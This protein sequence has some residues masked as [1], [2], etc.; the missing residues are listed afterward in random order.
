MPAAFTASITRVCFFAFSAPAA[1]AVS[2]CDST[3]TLIIARSGTTVV[4][5]RPLAAMLGGGCGGGVGP[6]CAITGTVASERIRAGRTRTATAPDIE[7]MAYLHRKLET[8]IRW[9][10]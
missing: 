5:P 1:A 6:G 8:Y 2:P 3:A 7:C 9:Y 4:S 10:T